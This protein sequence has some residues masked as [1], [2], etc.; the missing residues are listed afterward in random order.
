MNDAPDRYAPLTRTDRLNLNTWAKAYNLR[1]EGF[2][3]VEAAR[4]A[5]LSLLVDSGCYGDDRAPAAEGE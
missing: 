1:H 5:F 3:P 4:L 2:T